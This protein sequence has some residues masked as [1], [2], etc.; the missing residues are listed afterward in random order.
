MDELNGKFCSRKVF[1]CGSFLM[2]LFIYTCLCMWIVE[3]NFYSDMKTKRLN[4]YWH[5]SIQIK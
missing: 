3:S 4:E 5:P 1:T 2:F